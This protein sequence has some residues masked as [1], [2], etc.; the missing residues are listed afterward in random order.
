MVSRRCSDT[1]WK[2]LVG[3]LTS[4]HS[5]SETANRIAW[6]G[7]TMRT[8]RMDQQKPRSW[9]DLAPSTHRFSQEMCPTTTVDA[10]SGVVNT[11]QS[12]TLSLKRAISE[13]QAS[14]RQEESGLAQLFS[15]MKGLA[16]SHPNGQDGQ[17]QCVALVVEAKPSPVTP[18]ANRKADDDL[19]QTELEQ[20]LP[21]GMSASKTS[22][23]Q[24]YGRKQD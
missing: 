22:V 1:S 2:S 12:D 4:S 8:A 21:H 6:I 15:I 20:Q 16:V 18:P 19:E 11:L 5:S 14:L 7:K 3:K 10:L 24:Y 17:A 13:M 9:T 23:Q